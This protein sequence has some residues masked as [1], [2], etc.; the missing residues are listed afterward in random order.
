M[1]FDSFSPSPFVLPD[2]LRKGPL[3]RR[4]YAFALDFVVAWFVSSAIAGGFARSLLF[5]TIWLGDRVVFS[6]QNRGQSLGRWAFD[7]KAIDLQYL[8]LPSVLDLCK[9]EGLAGGAAAIAVAGLSAIF[10]ARAAGLLLLLPLAAD[11]GCAWTDPDNRQ[12]FHDRVG[13]T[14]VI[15]SRRG[16]SLDLKVRRLVASLRRSVQK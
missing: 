1:N 3:D 6:L 14:A 4:A 11:L 16:Y 10:S 5:L 12:A 8:R 7:L 9:R 15:S 13:R 2:R